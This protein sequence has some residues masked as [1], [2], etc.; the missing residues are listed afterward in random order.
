MKRGAD[1]ST[2]QHL[3]LPLP[4]ACGMRLRQWMKP[5]LGCGRSSEIL[6]ESGGGR[7]ILRTSLNQLTYLPYRKH[8][9]GMRE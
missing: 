2:D 3:A 7:N 8:S 6:T 9:L 1:P 5:K 4:L